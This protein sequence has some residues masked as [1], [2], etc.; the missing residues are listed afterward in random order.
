MSHHRQL[1]TETIPALKSADFDLTSS[2]GSAFGFAERSAVG[3][4]VRP[5]GGQREPDFN[6]LKQRRKVRDRA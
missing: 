1:V 3:G 5:P 2:F 4:P 6:M